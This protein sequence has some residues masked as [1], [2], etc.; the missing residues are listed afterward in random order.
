MK[1]YRVKYEFY[2]ND[3]REGCHTELYLLD[4]PINK[5]I[6][7]TD[8]D[9]LWYL[10]EEYPFIPLD[11][12]KFRKGRALYIR[13]SFYGIKEWKNDCRPWKLVITSKETTVSMD[14][15]MQFDSEDVIQYLKER[16][17]TTCP[18]NL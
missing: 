4:N 13:D 12:W 5:E 11:C 9:T 16:G 17:I 2:Y 6:S 1:P 18:M 15:L 14:R 7:G 3:R 10:V 8:F